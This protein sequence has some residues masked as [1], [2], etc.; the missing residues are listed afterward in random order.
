MKWWGWMRI[1]NEIGE[2]KLFRSFFFDENVV[3]Q[4]SQGLVMI[5]GIRDSGLKVHYLEIDGVDE[6][7]EL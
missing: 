4:C 5:S 2:F 1:M 3:V 7:C 6:Y